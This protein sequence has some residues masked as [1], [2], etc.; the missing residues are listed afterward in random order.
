ME[1]IFLLFRNSW[2][3]CFHPSSTDSLTVHFSSGYRQWLAKPPGSFIALGLHWLLLLAA[4]LVKGKEPGDGFRPPFCRY[5][6]PRSLLFL[7]CREEVVGPDHHLKASSQAASPSLRAFQR[8][9]VPP[10][11]R[12]QFPG[13]TVHF[14]RRLLT[15]PSTPHPAPFFPLLLTWKREAPGIAFLDTSSRSW[16]SPP[17]P[18]RGL[19]LPREG[20]AASPSRLCQ[21]A[22]PAVL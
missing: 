16:V 7:L 15:A 4:N 19:S 14:P 2:Q 22:P 12:L 9:R 1:F 11:S 8:E 10:P 6:H 13:Q 17:G 21:G 5:V 20:D 18:T 3:L